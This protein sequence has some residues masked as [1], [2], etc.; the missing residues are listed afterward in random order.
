MKEGSRLMLLIV[1][2]VFVHVCSKKNKVGQNQ[3]IFFS[4]ERTDLVSTDSAKNGLLIKTW[5]SP[6]LQ[7]LDSSLFNESISRF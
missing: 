2:I 1:A 4:V 5:I 3:L 7:G 6:P